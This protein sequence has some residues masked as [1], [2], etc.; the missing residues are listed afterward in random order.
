MKNDFLVGL[1]AENFITQ[2]KKMPMFIQIEVHA[3]DREALMDNVTTIS[4]GLNFEVFRID[5]DVIEK[6]MRKREDKKIRKETV[7]ESSDGLSIQ[8]SDALSRIKSLRGLFFI[9]FGEYESSNPGLIATRLKR[10][11]GEKVL[12][13]ITKPGEKINI[14][15]L[16]E[17]IRCYH[18][19]PPDAFEI[20]SIARKLPINNIPCFP[21]V[22]KHCL[23]L[24]RE[25]VSD[26][27]LRIF[28]FE[29]I[30]ELPQIASAIHKYKADYLL[31]NSEVLEYYF[32]NSNPHIFGYEMLVSWI[33]PI[34]KKIM[35]GTSKRAILLYGV[36]GTGKTSAASQIAYEFKLPLVKIHFSMLKD[37][38]QGEAERK[39]RYT[40]KMV[41]R[42]APCVMLGDEYDKTLSSVASNSS[43]DGG[44]GSALLSI[45]LEWI[46]KSVPVIFIGTSNSLNIRPEELRRFE[47]F[48]VD[49]P[50]KKTAKTILWSTLIENG[51][52][53]TFD[54]VA[55]IAEK[56]AG[57]FS[58]DLIKKTVDS[59]IANAVLNQG[60]PEINELQLG[61]EQYLD[62]AIS[63]HQSTL[64]IRDHAMMHGFKTIG[65]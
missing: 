26:L 8:L 9:E 47:P 23:G 32:I 5:R 56:M 38:L 43:V 50:G 44:V 33:K 40:L 54:E 60:K 25:A 34:Y 63:L 11:D 52:T 58:G 14:P 64:K 65:I 2:Q 61:Y 62:W 29:K 37:K 3:G 31:K 46:E 39:F 28:S 10:L 24:D 13:F 59:A 22:I 30:S 17:I 18:F 48:F 51:I 27:F 36:P 7:L 4:E 41:E 12:C 20:A 53:L 35:K 45:W 57:L 21:D 1:K 19:G 49:V 42:M 15:Y 16:E 6:L 55:E